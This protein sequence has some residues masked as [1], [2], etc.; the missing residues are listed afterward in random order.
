VRRQPTPET[1]ALAASGRI[2]VTPSELWAELG[3]EGDFA[4]G[5]VMETLLR[6]GYIPHP[7]GF[8]WA[9]DLP[10]ECAEPIVRAYKRIEA[11][12]PDEGEDETC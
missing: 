1:V 3:G 9:G 2:A 8:L 5:W 7:A 4:P 6:L 11:V 10:L 12:Y